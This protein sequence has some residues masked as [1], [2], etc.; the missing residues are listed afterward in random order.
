[1]YGKEFLGLIIPQVDHARGLSESLLL[2]PLG[3][4]THAASSTAQLPPV[5]RQVV[6]FFVGNIRKI[7]ETVYSEQDNDEPS[8]ELS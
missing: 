7:L 4:N 3:G 2:P 1:M 5:E 6:R 8:C